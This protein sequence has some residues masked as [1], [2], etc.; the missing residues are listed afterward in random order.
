MTIK[1]KIIAWAVAKVTSPK[2]KVWLFVMSFTESSFFPVPPDILLIAILLTPLRVKWV[3]YSTLTT[4]AS[5]LGGVFGYLIGLVLFEAIGASVVTLYGLEDEMV[6]VGELFSKNAFF[7]IFTA[8]FTPIP[9]KVFTISA[10]LFSIPI[11]PFITASIL[12]RGLRFL[13]VGFVT[14]RFGERAT[15]LALRYFN[16]LTLALVVIIGVILYIFI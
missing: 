11:I 2:N 3:S 5:V 13:A 8:A 7:A 9:Y 14:A 15:R 12:G 6:R 16:W 10:G 1:D 4:I